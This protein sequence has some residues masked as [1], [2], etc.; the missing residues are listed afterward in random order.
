M[1]R[2]EVN[3]KLFDLWTLLHFILAFFLAMVLTVLLENL[4]LAVLVAT[5]ISVSWEVFEYIVKRNYDIFNIP[6][7]RKPVLE[8]LDNVAMDLLFSEIGIV[9]FVFCL[10]F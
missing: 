2:Y 10:I 6:F 8:S 5:V 9:F 4:A 1:P 7:G 3:R